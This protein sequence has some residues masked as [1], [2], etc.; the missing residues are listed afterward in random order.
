[1]TDRIGMRKNL[2]LHTAW[3]QPTSKDNQPECQN[4]REKLDGKHDPDNIGAHLVTAYNP[5]NFC[6]SIRAFT[7]RKS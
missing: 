6:R 2:L 5:D 3:V 7:A 1:M 4:W